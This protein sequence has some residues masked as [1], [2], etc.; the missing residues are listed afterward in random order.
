[1]EEIVEAVKK[2]QAE[3]KKLVTIGG[4]TALAGGTYPQGEILLNREKMNQI[5]DL[6]K[7]TLTLTVEAGVTLNQV[8]DYLA[9]SG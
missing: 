5:L 7:E 6:D 2:A 1:E 8:R 9:G 3:G 4:H